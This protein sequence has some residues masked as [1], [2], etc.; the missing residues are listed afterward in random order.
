MLELR[1]VDV[2]RTTPRK[3]R[4]REEEGEK[5]TD[6]KFFP[7]PSCGRQTEYFTLTILLLHPPSPPTHP[8]V[9]HNLLTPHTVS[10]FRPLAATRVSSPGSGGIP[11][12]VNKRSSLPRRIRNCAETSVGSLST[13]TV[14]EICSTRVK[15]S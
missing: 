1:K 14:V 7:D 13:P 4:K 11:I 9:A 3:R 5:E 2:G 12:E 15:K 8:P 6:I 10:F